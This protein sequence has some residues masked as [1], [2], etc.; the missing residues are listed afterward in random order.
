MTKSC[1]GCESCLVSLTFRQTHSVPVR[2][3]PDT[4]LL[5][6]DGGLGDL[7]G[8]EELVVDVSCRVE[9]RSKRG[10]GT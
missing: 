2:G 3:G 8:R 9:V 1:S 4:A 7:A 6:E 5:A 10:G